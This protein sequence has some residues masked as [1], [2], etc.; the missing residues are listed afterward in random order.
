[1]DGPYTTEARSL[2]KGLPPLDIPTTKDFFRFYALTGGG[3]LDVRMTTESLNSQAERFFAGF[4]RVTGSII[5]EQDRAHIYDVRMSIS[6][7]LYLAKIVLLVGQKYL[8]SAEPSREQ[9]K[10]KAFVRSKGAGRV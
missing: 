10:T 8:S 7:S 3:Q 1:M 2:R 9:A 6:G 5:T 4:T